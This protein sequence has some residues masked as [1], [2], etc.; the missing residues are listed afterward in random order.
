MNTAAKQDNN[1]SLVAEESAEESKKRKRRRRKKDAD[2]PA[3][4]GKSRSRK[5]IIKL[6]VLIL[7]LFFVAGF[8]YASVRYDLWSVR[9]RFIGMVN[10]LDPAYV[11]VQQAAADQLR[12]DQQQLAVDQ[13]KLKSDREN[14]DAREALLN[15]REEQVETQEI[16]RT[17]IHRRLLTDQQREELQSLGKIYNNMEPEAAAEII[18][19]LYDV[20]DMATLLYFMNQAKAADVL[21]YMDPALA[22]AITEELLWDWGV[23][24]AN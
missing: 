11:G 18:T 14:L 5:R 20:I 19:E 2:S 13:A 10:R 1:L 15:L 3:G 16:A 7:L 12:A 4:E 6:V 17:P 9:S 8:L 22:A 24:S 21:T 23:S